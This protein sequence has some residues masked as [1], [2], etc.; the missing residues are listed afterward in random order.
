M[1]GAAVNVLD[2]ARIQSAEARA[3][4]EGRHEGDPDWL[5][6]FDLVE[7]RWPWRKAAYI[8]WCTQPRDQRQPDT[9]QKF[10]IQELGLTSARKVREWK[11][12]D[13]FLGFIKDMA[14]S[15]L[16]GARLDIFAALV[17][18]ATSGNPR[19]HA[20]R[21]MAFEMLGDY[22]QTLRLGSTLPD[23]LD[24]LGESDKRAQLADLRRRSQRRA[25]DGVD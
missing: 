5:I 9:E 8:A 10:A 17:E 14:K 6:Y 25:S 22:K 20:D 24:Q 4:F 2:Q 3:I 12:D 16:A 7:E 18:S 21:K 15:M 11:Q 23:D 1:A 19:N 13:E